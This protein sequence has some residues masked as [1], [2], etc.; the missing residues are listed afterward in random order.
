MLFRCG[1]ALV[2]TIVCLASFACGKKPPVDT[3]ENSRAEKEATAR[4]VRRLAE[5]GN[6]TAQNKLGLLY[7]VGRGVPQNYVQAKR[8]FEEAAK[9][10]HAGA[11]I[12]LGMLYLQEDAPPRSPQMAMF[13]FSR[14][15]EQGA[16]PAFA[17]L[18]QMYQEAQG[19]PEDLV[20]AYMW[21]HLAATNGEAPSAERR[22]LLATKMTS[23]QIAEAQKRAQEW[24]PKP[25]SVALKLRTASSGTLPDAKTTN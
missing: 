20:Q 8:W 23:A 25:K 17:K 2:L 16:A 15:A 5:E 22:D 18:G 1:I 12:N 13:W 10:G 7:K 21:F 4:E 9:Q 14:A 3:S 11:Q 24:K 19:V 6:V